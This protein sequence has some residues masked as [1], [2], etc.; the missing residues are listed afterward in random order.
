MYVC[1]DTSSDSASA[2][3]N[4]RE[5]PKVGEADL[6]S[7]LLYIAIIYDHSLNNEQLCKACTVES[8]ALSCASCM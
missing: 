8:V 4:S 3:L 2:E 7:T 5:Q 1:S 6:S